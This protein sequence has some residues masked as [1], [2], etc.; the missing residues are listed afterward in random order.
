MTYIIGPNEYR[1]NDLPP[2]HPLVHRKAAVSAHKPGEW[3]IRA[4]CPRNVVGRAGL[5]AKRLVEWILHYTGRFDFDGIEWWGYTYTGL[6]AYMDGR[7]DWSSGLTI[8][9]YIEPESATVR[10]AQAEGRMGWAYDKPDSLPI[11]EPGVVQR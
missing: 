9:R 7:Y 4:W 5:D 6:P 10:A 8:Q 2:L 3:L 1:L 11:P